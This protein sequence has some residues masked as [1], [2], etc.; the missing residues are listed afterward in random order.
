MQS[1]DDQTLQ[2][3]LANGFNEIFAEV[4][5]QNLMDSRCPAYE[6]ELPEI[7]NMELEHA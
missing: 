4:A 7:T 1:K 3:K 2:G 6:D 5:A